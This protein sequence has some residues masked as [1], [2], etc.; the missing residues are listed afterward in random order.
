METMENL[1]RA[2]QFQRWPLVIFG[3]ETGGEMVCGRAG[4]SLLLV[5]GL[6]DEPLLVCVWCR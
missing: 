3:W 6:R 1:A 2:L 5:G 4:G